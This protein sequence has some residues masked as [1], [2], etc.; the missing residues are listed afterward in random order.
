MATLGLNFGDQ[1]YSEELVSFGRLPGPFRAP[2]GGSFQ[3]KLVPIF[4]PTPLHALSFRTAFWFQVASLWILGGIL[5][6]LIKGCCMLCWL[7]S[8]NS[9]LLARLSV[10]ARV[11][12][13][14]ALRVGSLLL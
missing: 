6:A 2:A 11:M 14:G 12:G 1:F 5:I 4:P 10:G 9:G 13:E 3:C 7:F 8:N